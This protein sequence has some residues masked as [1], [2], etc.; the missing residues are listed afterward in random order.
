MKKRIIALLAIMMI[1]MLPAVC[2]GEEVEETEE[3]L[4]SGDYEYFLNKDD[5]V[6]II[7]W[8]GEDEYLEIPSTIDGNRVTT[9]DKGVFANYSN[10]SSITIPDS[11]TSIGANAFSDCQSLNQITVSPQNETYAVIDNVL[12]NKKEKELVC[13][14]A[15]LGS[16][17]YC[18]P[19][20]T[21]SIGAFSFFG[22]SSLHNIYIPDSVTSIGKFA[23]FG[24]S[25][26]SSIDIPD[27]VTSI[28]DRAFSECGSLSSIDI[29]DS[30]TSIG[31]GAFSGCSSLSNMD[32]PDSVM[33]IGDRAFSSCESLNQIM[34]SPENETYAVIDNVLFNKKEKELVCYPAG[35]NAGEYCIPDGIVSI[36]AVAF[37]FCSSLRNVE[38]PDSVTSIGDEAFKYCSSL[39]NIDI[40]DSVTSIGELAFSFCDSL[41]SIEIPDSVTSIGNRAFFNCDNAILLVGRDAYASQYAK[42]NGLSYTYPDANDWL[43]D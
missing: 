36:G 43:N 23:I 17:E 26:L 22:C 12:F 28:G 18:I 38:I 24:C 16:E 6:T 37:G 35:L 7:D 29:P 9:I 32:I 39:S 3:I 34:V 5:T 25:S 21:V 4:T 41:S 8:D 15:G 40:P 20:G 33:S 19:D 27:S 10:L 1:K 42:D 31:E 2:L 13:Y 14:P 30:V 11:V